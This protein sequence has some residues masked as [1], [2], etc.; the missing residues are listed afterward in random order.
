MKTL[1]IAITILATMVSCEYGRIY[2]YE[3]LDNK[4]R[5]VKLKFIDSGNI[6]I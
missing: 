4:G 3:A 6:Y 1:A 5:I 2:E